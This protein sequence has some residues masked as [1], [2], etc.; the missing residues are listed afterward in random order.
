MLSL[1]YSLNK[2]NFPGRYLVV[3][4]I[5]ALNYLMATI[6]I[7]EVAAA[8]RGQQDRLSLFQD[9]IIRPLQE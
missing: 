6:I 1:I 9:N 7:M 3:F 5:V 4:L 8:H 2:L